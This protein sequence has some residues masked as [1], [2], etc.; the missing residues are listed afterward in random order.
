M[1]LIDENGSEYSP[2]SGA[3]M[4]PDSLGLITELNPEVT[5]K[6]AVIF[7]VPRSHRYR[8]QVSGGYGLREVEYFNLDL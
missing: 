8:L 5:K 7:D 6:G 3:W 2:D 4:L 1:K